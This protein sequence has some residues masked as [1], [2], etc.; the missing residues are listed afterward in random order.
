MMEKT[1]R[2]QG[3]DCQRNN[4]ENAFFHSVDKHSPDFG[5]SPQNSGPEK[6]FARRSRRCTQMKNLFVCVVCICVNLR[7]TPNLVAGGPRW[8]AIRQSRSFLRRFYHGWH[9]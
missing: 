9:G 2:S 5:F 4:H 3:N 7:A 6:T 8:T 1:E